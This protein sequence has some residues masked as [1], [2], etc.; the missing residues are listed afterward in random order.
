MASVLV[1]GDSNCDSWLTGVKGGRL[2]DGE[3][4]VDDWG[5]EACCD[6]VGGLLFLF[7]DILSEV[8]PTSSRKLFTT[9]RYFSPSPFPRET[10]SA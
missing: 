9:W 1:S 8:R 7:I 5:G 6:S 2:S 10:I 4:C 3:D